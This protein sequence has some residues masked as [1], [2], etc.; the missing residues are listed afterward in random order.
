MD[1][2]F[3]FELLDELDEPFELELLDELELLFEFEFE[4]EFREEFDELLEL[5]LEFPLPHRS[6]SPLRL[7]RAWLAFALRDIFSRKRETG[8]SAMAGAGAAA[9][10]IRTALRIAI[11]FF[12]VFLLCRGSLIGCGGE[13]EGGEV[14][15]KKIITFSMRYAG[16]PAW[17]IAAATHGSDG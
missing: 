12:M 10:A 13:T 7:D 5:R 17:E 3:E 15:S 9:P 14:Y 4:L 16:F 6:S 2:E 11:S 1:D 8:S